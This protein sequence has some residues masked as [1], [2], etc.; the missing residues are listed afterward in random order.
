MPLPRPR[1]IGRRIRGM[2]RIP[3][4][5]KWFPPSLPLPVDIGRPA[6][7]EGIGCATISAATISNYSGKEDLVVRPIIEPEIEREL[8][9]AS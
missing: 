7:K 3:Q 1:R 4:L 2:P 6:V 8:R 5:H 9:V